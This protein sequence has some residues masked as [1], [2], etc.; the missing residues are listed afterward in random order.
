MFK[1]IVNNE[2]YFPNSISENARSLINVQNF[3]N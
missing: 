2:V 1:Q 3:K